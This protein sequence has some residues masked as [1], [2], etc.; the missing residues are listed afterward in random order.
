MGPADTDGPRFVSQS[1]LPSRASSATNCP[2][3]P[4]ANNTFDL[5]VST[6]LSVEGADNLNVHLR[7][8]VAGSMAMI[9][10]KTSS[11]VTPPAG[12]SPMK[13]PLPNSGGSS[14]FR[15]LLE[16]FSHAGM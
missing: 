11:P 1:N 6:P 10:L 2:S 4:P 9:E 16:L 3:R 12:P 8:P 13:P 5:V 15:Y 7:S 14:L